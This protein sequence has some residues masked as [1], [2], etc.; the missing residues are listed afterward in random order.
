MH[1][2]QDTKHEFP[3]WEALYQEHETES[4]PW[5][6]PA[7]DDDLNIALDE[8]GLRGGSVLDLGIGPGTQAMQLARRGFSVTATD[9]SGEA[10]RR[11]RSKAEEQGFDITWE[12]DDILDTRFTRQFDL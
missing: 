4:M 5:F 7:L 10:I 11:A 6:H 2:S 1:M 9:I 12:Q 3:R 8:L